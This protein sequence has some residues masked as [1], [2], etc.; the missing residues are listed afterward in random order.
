MLETVR[1]GILGT[2]PVAQ[3]FAQG[4]RTLPSAKFVA[5]G[6]RTE[7]RARRFATAY[8]VPRYHTDY[9][10]FFADPDIDVVYIATPNHRHKIDALAALDAGKAV[11][12]EKP[13]TVNAAEAAAVIARA[14]ETGLLCVEGMWMRFLPLMRR[15]PEMLAEL[16][17]VSLLNANLGHAFKYD[18]ANSM[19]DPATGGATLDLGVYLVSLATLCFGRPTAIDSRLSLAPNG[20]DDQMSAVLEFAGGKLAV[21]SAS[22]RTNGANEA[23]F[24]GSRGRARVH[25]PLYRANEVTVANYEQA[26]RITDP[27]Q[28]GLLSRVK[29]NRTVRAAFQRAAAALPRLRGERLVSIGFDGNG[30]NYEA[31]EVMRCMRAGLTES[32]VMPL[33][34]TLSVMQVIDAIRVSATGKTP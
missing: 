21:L 4:L 24:M 34:D 19:F 12:C 28:P 5:V 8:Q 31:E 10:R 23:V 26:E 15:L 17:E 18:A 7:E 9:E 6:S 2:G 33:D 1:W 22:L 30:Y 13:F 25:A 27:A 29:A 32:P 14:R 20:V 16:G 3:L 11:L